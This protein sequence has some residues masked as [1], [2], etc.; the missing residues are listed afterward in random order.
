MLSFSGL[1]SAASSSVRSANN[2]PK[3]VRFAATVLG[4]DSDTSQQR[5]VEMTPAVR[6]FDT[7]DQVPTIPPFTPPSLHQQ[8]ET[9][10]EQSELLQKALE[11]QAYQEAIKAYT[12][13]AG[14]IRAAAEK[15]G[16]QG[17]SSDKEVKDLLEK[18]LENNQ[19][20]HSNLTS[21]RRSTAHSHPNTQFYSYPPSPDS[22]AKKDMRV[23]LY[24]QA[25]TA[26]IRQ[27]LS[28]STISKI[29]HM[30][31]I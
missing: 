20:I 3:M 24:N 6:S 26:Y 31:T 30:V 2:P 23:A 17:G 28:F 4:L 21:Y 8:I 7:R 25:I 12:E 9:E 15:I 11:K 29:G 5:E 14:E 13:K 16:A 19:V 18:M 22:E 27:N 10:G 1:P